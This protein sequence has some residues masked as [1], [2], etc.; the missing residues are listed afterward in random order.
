MNE[1]NRKKEKRERTEERRSSERKWRKEKQKKVTMIPDKPL[2]CLSFLIA[3]KFSFFSLPSFFSLF[4]V[5]FLYLSFLSCRSHSFLNAFFFFSGMEKSLDV[6]AAVKR[7]N[8]K[9]IHV[10]FLPLF[11]F[12]LLHVF[13]FLSVFFT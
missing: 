12:F 13:F 2:F 9:S 5:L 8:E 7:E 6:M 11:I 4:L 1:E 3:L 10:L